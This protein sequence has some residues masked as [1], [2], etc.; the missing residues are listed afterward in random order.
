MFV[1]TQQLPVPP[2]RKQPRAAVKPQLSLDVIIDTAIR[3]LDTDGLSALSMRRVAEELNTGA[4]SLYAYVSNKDELLELVYERVIAEIEVPQVDPARWEQQ[5]RDLCW[6]MYRVLSAHNDI[7]R[8]AL[9]NVPIGPNALRVGEATM[10]IMLAGGVPVQYAAWAVDRLTLYI[11]ADVYE[12]SLY[13]IRQ[14]ASGKDMD[15]YIKDYFGGIRAYYESLPP[16]LFPAM[17][18]NLDAMMSGDG[19]DRFGFGLDLMINSLVA[20]TKVKR[21]R[22]DKR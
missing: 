4:A 5:L 13:A 20:S 8:V 22:I 3:V 12:G 10:A 16:E 6:S 11:S 1:M 21:E 14:K 19:D 9:A 18:S 7:A 17:S 15:T 2:W